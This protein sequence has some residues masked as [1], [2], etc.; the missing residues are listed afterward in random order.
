MRKKRRSLQSKMPGEEEMTERPLRAP[1][2]VHLGVGMKETK[3]EM[4][5]GMIVVMIG[6]EE[7]REDTIEIEGMIEDMIEIGEMTGDMIGIKDRYDMI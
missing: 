7:M 2:I 3:G 5:G 4:I 1:R 6:I